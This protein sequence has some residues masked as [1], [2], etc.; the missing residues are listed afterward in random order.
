MFLVA[1]KLLLLILQLNIQPLRRRRE[2]HLKTRRNGGEA[3]LCVGILTFIASSWSLRNWS[4]WAAL[5]SSLMEFCVST[6]SFSSRA[7]L[8]MA[9]S[10]SLENQQ[11]S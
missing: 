6:L 4:I 2:E 8:W 11:S 7:T 3:Y 5:S 1:K 10:S 9:T